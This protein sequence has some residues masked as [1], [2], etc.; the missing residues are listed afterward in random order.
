MHGFDQKKREILDRVDILQIVS[1]HMALKRNG[2]RWVGLCC[3]HQEK[4]P[5]FTVTPEQGFF[6]CFGCGKGGDVFSFVQFREN[7]SFIEAMRILAD[8]AGIELDR[9]RAGDGVDRPGRADVARANTWAVQFFRATLMDSEIGRS[10]RDYLRG[11]NISDDSSQRFELGLATE[12]GPSLVASAARAGIAVPLLL[13]ADL[14]R[15]SD[16]GRVYETF[17][18]RIMFP[19]K[20][21]TSRPIGF[22]GRTLVDDR[23]KY[24]NTRQNVLFDKGRNLYGV[25]LARDAFTRQSR[26]V[27]VEGYTDCVAAHQAGFTETVA[28]LGTAL[29]EAQVELLRRYCDELILLFDSDQAGEA[30]AQRAIVVAYPLCMEVRMAQ[31]PEGKDPSEFLSREGADRFRDVL[32][33]AVEALELLWSRILDR[34]GGGASPAAQRAAV[35]HF[36]GIVAKAYWA[37]AMDEI[38]RGLLANQVAHLLGMDR[39]EIN[40]RLGRMRPREEKPAVERAGEL[41]RV[42]C[43]SAEQ[44][45]WPHLLGVLLNEP[46]LATGVGD[47]LDVEQIWDQRVRRIAEVVLG[48]AGRRQEFSVRDVLAHF[49]DTEDV[50]R[51]TELV[52]QGAERGNFANTMRVALERIS[53][54][55]RVRAWEQSRLRVKGRLSEQVDGKDAAEHLAALRDGVREHHHFAP[56]RMIRQVASAPSAPAGQ[57]SCDSASPMEQR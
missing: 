12:N 43:V 6:K 30:A 21:A 57:R 11:R 10:A 20:D 15:Q 19:I 18:N 56:R 45:A 8:R 32:N 4:T 54:A 38:Q 47:V 27:V 44:A 39:A 17:R 51:I 22:G 23:A 28:M 24:L 46:G 7:V 42:A 48:M 14:V 29:T 52:Q 31:I 34:F 33:L 5:S 35:L 3:F 2:K 49:H 50:G 36:L 25:D 1:E 55:A 26:A 41:P 13:A 53:G 16:D 9:Q 40:N 37:G